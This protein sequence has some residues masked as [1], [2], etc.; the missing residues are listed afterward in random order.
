MNKLTIRSLTELEQH[1]GQELGVS[2]YHIIT[3]PQI[4][5]FAAATLDHQWIHVDAERA[6]T[7]SP[8]KATIAHGYLTVSLLPY[9]WQQIVTIENLKMQVNYEIEALRFNQ[10]VTVDSAVRLRA[11]LVAVKNLR[12]IAKA[13]L[14]VTLEI[15]DQPKPAYTGLITFLYHFIG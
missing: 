2:D 8:F 9:L 6:A 13:Q 15:K 10:A 7:E 1:V 11:K 5:S 4:N 12:G 3:Q 14:E